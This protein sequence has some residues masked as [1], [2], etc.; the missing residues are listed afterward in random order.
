MGIVLG[1]NSMNSTRVASGS[2]MS[3]C[4][5]PSRPISGC[6]GGFEAVGFEALDGGLH[7]G[8]A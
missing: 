5:L 3:N 2:K 8:D 4:I 6:V 1:S 7:G